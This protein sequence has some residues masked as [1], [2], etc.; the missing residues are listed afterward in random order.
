VLE[1]RPDPD[2]LARGIAQ[3]ISEYMSGVQAEYASSLRTPA[4]YTTSGL[5]GQ[6]GLS[7]RAIRAAIERGDL[8]AV[9]HGG[10]WFIGH[11]AVDAF[12]RPGSRSQSRRRRKSSSGGGTLGRF[13][14]Q[15]QAPPRNRQPSDTRK[16]PDDAG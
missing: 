8:L 6:L 3:S 9:K 4:G 7:T 1:N 13:L 14:E 5:A 12:F 2:E 16:K 15:E 11:E 10:R